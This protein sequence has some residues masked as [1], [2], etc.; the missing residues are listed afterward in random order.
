[1]RALTKINLKDVLFLDIE[2]STGVKELEIDSPLFNSWKYKIKLDDNNDVVESY[3][4]EAALYADF[5][6]IVCISIGRVFKGNFVTTT[7]NDFDEAELIRNFYTALEKTDWLLAGHAIKQFDIPYIFQRSI[8]N[9]IYPHKLIDTSGL[10]PW[11]M[12]WIYD[13]KELWSAGGFNKSGLVNITTA[14]GL[15]S[16]KEGIVGSEVP[17]YFWEDP[18][19]HIKEISDYCERDVVAVYNVLNRLKNPELVPIEQDPVIKHLFNGG[20]Y[21]EEHKEKLINLIKGL[22]SDEQSKVYSILD[23]IVSTAAG[24][25]TKFT[26]THV[27][28]LRNI[29]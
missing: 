22:S 21:D 11:E 19:G 7:F 1:M 10:K 24:K 26:K 18:T 9:G 14:F 3:K 29:C 12:D 17:A 8:I 27:K 23:A 15:P 25:K 5:G 4:R 20:I 2:T 6:R 28:E 16:P 13:T